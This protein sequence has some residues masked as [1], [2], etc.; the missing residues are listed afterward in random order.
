[1]A[2]NIVI[3]FLYICKNRCPQV[4]R[5]KCLTKPVVLH[6]AAGSPIFPDFSFPS[7]PFQASFVS[8]LLG[9]EPLIGVYQLGGLLWGTY[10]ILP[11]LP[12]W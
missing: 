3:R 9:I 2:K 1:M 6:L 10:R 12:V 11:L 5:V 4:A 7:S 8:I